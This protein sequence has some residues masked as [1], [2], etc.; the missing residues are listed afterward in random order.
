MGSAA[1]EN[2][3]M[4][5]ETPLNA[6]YAKLEEV[7]EGFR[8]LYEERGGQFVIT[9]INGIKTDADVTRVTRAL[10]SEKEAHGKLKTDWTG[11]F[12]EQKPE[13]VRAVLDRVPE[14]EAAA[15]GKLDDDKINGIVDTRVR[16]KLAPVERENG[17]LKTAVAERD[18]KIAQFEQ[19]ETTRTIHDGVRAEAS[20]LKV[21]DSAVEDVLMLAERQFEINDDGQLVTKDGINGLTPGLSPSV[22]LTEMQSKRPHWWPASKGGGANGGSGLPAGFA[23]NPFSHAHWNMTEQGRLHNV[24]P[25]KARQMAEVAGTTIGGLRPPAPAK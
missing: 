5:L 17:Q 3:H 10:A 6:Q 19:R 4:P 14:L 25:A 7:P 24:D 20:K 2:H 9:K 1:K 18:Q 12:G 21:V 11:F 8:D 22:W 16:S 15:A 23:N 13:D